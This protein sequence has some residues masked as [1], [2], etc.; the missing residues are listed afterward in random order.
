MRPKLPSAERLAPYLRQIDEARFY[1]N[2]GPLVQRL[3]ARLAHRFGLPVEGV[4]TVANAT[5]G[6]ALA[7]GALEAPVGSLCVLP[8]WTFIASAHAAVMA[9]LVP[10]FVDVGAANW[11]LDP[12]GVA[13][14]IA[15]A[16]ARVGSA[17]LRR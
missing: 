15:Q 2:F 12:D 14:M 10:Y 16:P 6:L 5:L 1:S 3:E 13:E 4:T 8:A 9:G 11:A 7:L 17:F